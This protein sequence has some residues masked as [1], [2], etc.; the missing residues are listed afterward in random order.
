MPVN[1]RT[2]R[3]ATPVTPYHV[4]VQGGEFRG[5]AATVTRRPPTGGGGEPENHRVDELVIRPPSSKGRMNQSWQH[6]EGSS[7]SARGV[8][9]ARA[10]VGTLVIAFGV[11][12]LRPVIV[13]SD[14]MAAQLV[15]RPTPATVPVEQLVVSEPTPTQPVSASSNSTSKATAV[16]ATESTATPT[17]LTNESIEQTSLVTPNPVVPHYQLT[18]TG[19]AGRILALDAKT[20][21]TV[22]GLLDALQASGQLTYASKQYDYGVFIT[23][24][25]GVA[26]DS[27][28]R[29]YWVYEVNGQSA[30]VGADQY[31]LKSGDIVVWNYVK[32]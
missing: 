21:I 32:T 4:W 23:A 7:R 18:I 25:D 28:T 11:L 27:A 3:W 5:S 29:Q 31:Q 17:G 26:N 14:H 13:W 30:T 15:A 22:V 24:I 10:L 8:F 6:G 2:S 16:P 9:I 12:A 1:K 20:E 19:P